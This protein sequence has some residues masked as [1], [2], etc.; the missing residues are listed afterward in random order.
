MTTFQETQQLF[1]AY[2]NNGDF[3]NLRDCLDNLDEIIDSHDTESQKAIEFKKTIARYID[4]QRNDIFVKCNIQ[5]FAKDIKNIRDR[6]LLID[7][8]TSLLSAS[9]S[10]EDMKLFVELLDIKSDYFK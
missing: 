5:D 2:Q 8:L 7:K 3:L 6:D 1:N 10:D 9:F 4:K